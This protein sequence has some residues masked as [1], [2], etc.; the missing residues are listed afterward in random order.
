M[1][2]EEKN[3]AADPLFSEEAKVNFEYQKWEKIGDKVKGVLVEKRKNENLDQWGHKKME[4]ILIA[5]GGRRVCVSGRAY[6]KGLN[7]VGEDYKIIFGMN[8]IP[9]G[10]V[11]AFVYSKDLENDKGNDTKVIEPRYLGEKD[12]DVL[13][14]Y[15][16]K[17][18]GRNDEITVVKNQAP[19]ADEIEVEKIPLM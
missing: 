5:D 11:M 16:E 17:W 14:E 13:R 7:R 18:N 19:E 3:N 2:K 10:A 4:Y 12:E 15:Q 9:L 8:E 1:T 6:P